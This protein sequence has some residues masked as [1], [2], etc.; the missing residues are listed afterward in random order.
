MR[1]GHSEKSV[2]PLLRARKQ[3]LWA[4]CPFVAPAATRSAVLL[5]L[6]AGSEQKLERGPRAGR[7]TW[8]VLHVVELDRLGRRYHALVAG[9]AAGCVG[10]R[11][12]EPP[13]LPIGGIEPRGRS[14]LVNAPA[15]TVHRGGTR[16]VG[17]PAAARQRRSE[18]K[19]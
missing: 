13:T 9:N 14:A 17:S 18:I 2:A 12:A 10:V 15:A 3:R 6:A 5:P 11:F 1:R 19:R 4:H 8:P 16:A 7:L